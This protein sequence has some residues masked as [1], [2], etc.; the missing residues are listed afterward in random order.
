MMR[1]QNNNKGNK[2][3]GFLNQFMMLLLC[4][5][6]GVT[7]TACQSG[8]QEKKTDTASEKKAEQKENAQIP[9]PFKDYAD[10][11]TVKEKL[12]FDITLPEKI[13]G[14]EQNLIQVDEETKL[15]QVFYKKGDAQILIRK[16][17]EKSDISGDYTKYAKEETATVGENTVTLKGNG[18]D[19][20]LAVWTTNEYSFSI[21][22]SEGMSQK[23][24]AELVQAVK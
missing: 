3:K 2:G 18:D 10:M 16:S 24:L 23:A 21:S 12:G 5:I 15:I 6:I 1:N 19:Y 11:A 7:A 4:L 20:K 9:S 17:P 14:Y 8:T 13:E 22:V